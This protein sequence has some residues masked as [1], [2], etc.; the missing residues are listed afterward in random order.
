MKRKVTIV[1]FHYA[2]SAPQIAVSLW[3]T[4]TFLSFPWKLCLPAPE[5]PWYVRRVLGEPEAHRYV[6]RQRRPALGREPGFTL[7]ISQRR[8]RI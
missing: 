4:V 1:V 3:L 7:F 8:S 6:G 2:P 5:A